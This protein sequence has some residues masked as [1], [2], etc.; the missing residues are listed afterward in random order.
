[1]NSSKSKHKRVAP[2]ESTG[3][4][5]EGFENRVNG[6]FAIL[7]LCNGELSILPGLKVSRLELQTRDRGYKTDDGD[8]QNCPRYHR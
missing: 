7:M 3:G 4:A 8:V 6:L 1:M 5:G 2:S